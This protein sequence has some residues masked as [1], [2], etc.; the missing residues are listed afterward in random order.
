LFYRPDLVSHTAKFITLDFTLC[1]ALAQKLK[2]VAT[3]GNSV[4]APVR[5]VRVS[6]TSD[7]RKEKHH[8]ANPENPFPHH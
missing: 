6:P 3:R 7:I 2:G 8:Q 1:I 5:A 4:E